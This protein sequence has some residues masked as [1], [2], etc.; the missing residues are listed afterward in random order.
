LR[1]TAGTRRK[2]NQETT[3][4]SLPIQLREKEKE[5]ESDSTT[6]DQATEE[7]KTDPTRPRKKEKKSHGKECQ[8]RKSQERQASRVFLSGLCAL[9]TLDYVSGSYWLL[10][11]CPDLIDPHLFRR[12]QTFSCREDER[13]EPRISLQQ[14]CVVDG[15]G[16]EEAAAEEE[17]EP[18]DDGDYEGFGSWSWIDSTPGIN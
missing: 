18:G 5:T 7:A 9:Q 4:A 15:E 8:D 17:E 11:S 1:F 14:I 12:K 3:K 6:E 16:D 13:S 10:P 2:R